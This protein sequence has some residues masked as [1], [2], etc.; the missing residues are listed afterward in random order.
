[1]LR[2]KEH[3]ED[4]FSEEALKYR[5][6]GNIRGLIYWRFGGRGEC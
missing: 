2:E 5:E 4:S 6:M 1:M 3:G